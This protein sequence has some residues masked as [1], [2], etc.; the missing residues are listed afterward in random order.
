MRRIGAHAEGH[1]AGRVAAIMGVV[2]SQ[3]IRLRNYRV[4]PR[5]ARVELDGDTAALVLPA[6]FGRHRWRV[7][8]ADLAVVDL[9]SPMFAP[10]A[11]ED[12]FRNGLATPYFFTTGPVT[13][14][15]T[16]LLFRAPQRV[17]PLRAVAAWAPNVDLPFGY[18]ESRSKRGAF[19]DGAFLR[20]EDPPNAAERLVMA[21]AERVHNP[22]QWL[23]ANREVVTDPVEREQ[24]LAHGR[25]SLW[26]SRVS[27]GLMLASLIGAAA[28]NTRDGITAAVWSLP[29]LG[30]AFAWLMRHLAKSPSSAA[31]S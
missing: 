3:T 23:R 14:P 10:D 15:T 30:L 17:S 21:G 7:Q 18:R 4:N 26:F 31:R 20:A 6:Y 16:L 29:V 2:S 28:L 11:G 8:L 22:A 27:N 25:R 5:E 24:V 12:V 19:V 13:A 9:T 1:V